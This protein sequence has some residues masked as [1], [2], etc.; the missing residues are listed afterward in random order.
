[1]FCKSAL[2]QPEIIYLPKYSGVPNQDSPQCYYFA[3][4]HLLAMHGLLNSVPDFVKEI[5]QQCKMT[6]LEQHRQIIIDAIAQ[7]ADDLLWIAD[8]VFD[9]EGSEADVAGMSGESDEVSEESDWAEDFFDKYGI[10]LTIA[11]LLNLSVIEFQKQDFTPA[12]LSKL[13]LQHGPIALGCTH[14]NKLPQNKAVLEIDRLHSADGTFVCTVLN[15]ENFPSSSAH[16][17]LVIGCQVQPDP[18]VYFIDPNYPADIL[19]MSFEK[20]KSNISVPEFAYL[21][22]NKLQ[23]DYVLHAGEFARLHDSGANYKGKPAF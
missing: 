5:A 20:F 14:G 16:Y 17:A 21:P 6:V 7:N 19:S 15:A 23:P 18:R 3:F 12:R 8:E 10:E 22:E 11:R 13:L 2:P 1:M 9:E 4:L